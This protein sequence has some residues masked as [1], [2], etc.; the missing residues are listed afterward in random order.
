MHQHKLFAAYPLDGE[1]QI[2]G[3]TLTTPYQIYDG[4]IL[5]FGG[6]AQADVARELLQNEALTPILDDAGNALMALWVCNFTDANLGPHTELQ[7]SLF[8]S[9][10]PQARV[11]AHP[12]AIYRLLTLNPQAMMVCHGLWN[13][14]ERVVRY[15]RE[16]LGLNAHLCQSTIEVDDSLR[17]WRFAY[18]DA[19][20]QAPLVQGEITPPG[21][22]PPA[23]LWQMVQQL[24]FGG[25]W[26]SMTAPFVHVPVVNTKSAVAEAN[27]VAH[28]YTSAGRQTISFFNDTQQV[29]IL[30][31]PYRALSF[32]PDFVQCAEAI[33]FVYLRP[34]PIG[35]V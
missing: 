21:A 10:T 24:G 25:M 35:A 34:V 27:L 28:T 8:A 33:K 22:Q 16:H 2:D 12:L 32:R 13:N 11:A 14:T 1:V 26:K 4:S 19:T 7:I 6:R 23:L 31:D 9:F 3:E 30:A 5:L 20:S 15:N 29:S 17:R 18:T